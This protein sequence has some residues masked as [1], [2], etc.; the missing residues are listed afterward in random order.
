[1]KA[2]RKQLKA[3]LAPRVRKLGLA[4]VALKLVEF[5]LFGKLFPNL[6]DFWD[7][8]KFWLFDFLDFLINL[9]PTS[10]PTTSPL[11]FPTSGSNKSSDPVVFSIEVSGA[12]ILLKP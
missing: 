4:S 7:L 5:P 6:A 1:M 3:F 9:P 2:S 8:D 10:N 12:V 11:P